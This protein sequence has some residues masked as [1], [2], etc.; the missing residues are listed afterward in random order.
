[1]QVGFWELSQSSEKC[2]KYRN[3]ENEGRGDE[4]EA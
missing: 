1:M 4:E 3:I 2:E